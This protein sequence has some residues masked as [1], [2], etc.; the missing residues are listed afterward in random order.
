MRSR[1]VLFPTCRTAEGSARAKR[2]VV[3]G[4]RRV[5]LTE[6]ATRE[7]RKTRGYKPGVETLGLET[8]PFDSA[9]STV[10]RLRFSL[11]PTM[12]SGKSKAFSGGEVSE[13]LFRRESR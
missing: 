2:A 3:S 13:I 11:R 12:M 4:E 1:L 10:C 8:G 7:I 5:L 6:G 9:L